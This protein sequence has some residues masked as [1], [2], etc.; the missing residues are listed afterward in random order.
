MSVA[1]AGRT[2]SPGVNWLYKPAVRQ[3]VI[4]A[5]LVVAIL[6]LIAWLVHN[7]AVNLADRH[8][9]SGFGFLNQRSSFDIVT[10]LPLTAE[11]SYG[12][13]I[14]AGLVDTIIVSVLAIIIATIVGVLVGIARLSS[15]WLI[16]ALSTVYVETLRNIPPLLV[17][18]FWYLAV[19]A[20][21][22]SPRDAITLGSAISLSNRGFY[23]PKPIF[24]APFVW[25]VGAF[26]IS[27]VVAYFVKRW[28][29]A[30]QM[31]T[32]TPFH[33]FW[34][35]LAIVVALTLIA[36]VATG[37]PLSFEVP[38]KTRFNVNGG[39]TLSPE[40][41]S[42]LLALALYTAS[43]IAEIV[44]AGIL[45][46]SHGQTEAARALG[47]R[48]GTTLRLVI[49]PQAL[50]VIVPPLTSEYL[51]IIKNSSLAVAVG[52]ADLVAVGQSVL[53]PTGQAIEVVAIWMTFYLGLSILTSVGMN[54][55]NR[56]IALT[57]R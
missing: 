26:A 47:L 1:D 54:I 8:I 16:R 35:G 44:R 52:Y 53:N 19:I 6:G 31:R 36:F 34:A 48:H 41:T 23:M 46:V 18:L 27:L 25:T 5:A 14:L 37:A 21:L 56:R 50:R 40:F 45:A 39:L 43:F 10:F 13:A 4:Q 57:E 2:S 29:S 7:T 30:R 51:N 3:F 38:V 33:S 17:I 15:N 49:L 9:A 11:D 22:P 24:G 42:L 55:F 32:G 20:A 12:R 28:A